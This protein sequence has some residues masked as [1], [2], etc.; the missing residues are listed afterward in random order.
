VQLAAG[1][2]TGISKDKAK[3]AAEAT[4]AF[5][6]KVGKAGSVIE[7]A[8]DVSGV[9]PVKWLG[10]LLSTAGDASKKEERAPDLVSLKAKLT[11]ALCELGHRFI[12]T[13]DD[14]DRLEPTEALEVLRLVRSVADFPNIIYVLCYD[15]EILSHSIKEAAKVKD[16]RAYLEK[17]VQLTVMVP[18]PEPFELRHWFSQELGQIASV[19]GYEERWVQRVAATQAWNISAGV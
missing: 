5:V 13:I 9:G 18:K 12:V 14:L 4:R 11:T 3:A 7:F 15:S 6:E 2:A 1:D 8:G 10:K 19:D 17:I 16:G